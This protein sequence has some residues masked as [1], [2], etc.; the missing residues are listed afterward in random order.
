MGEL[1]G[2][3]AL[4][5]N[6]TVGD[7]DIL[8]WLRAI[9]DLGYADAETAVAAHYGETTERLMPGHVRARVKA[10]RADRL[11][12]E[13]VP[14]PPPELADQPG[15]YKAALTGLIA[16]IADGFGTRMAIAAGPVREGPPPVEFTQARALMPAPPTG[17]ELARLQAE[18]SRTLREAADRGD[19][20]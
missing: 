8:A 6:R 3:A 20:Q 7:A 1:L 14:A 13:I 4:Y 15:R 2:F 9:G 18:E 11:A 10:M 19:A 5:D 12:R 17:E 16:R